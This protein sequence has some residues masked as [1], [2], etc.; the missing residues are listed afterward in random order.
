M[1]KVKILQGIPASGK[2]TWAREFVSKN[3]DWIIVSRDSLRRMRGEYWIPSQEGLITEWEHHLIFSTL[4]I[5]KL[6]VIVDATNLNPTYL[7]ILKKRLKA[8][9]HKYEIKKFDVSLEE[10]IK[11]D[12]KREN[13]VGA[14]VIKKFWDNYYAAPPVPKMVQNENLPIAIICDIDGTIADKGSRSPFDY[15]K[16]DKDKPKEEIIEI[17]KLMKNDNNTIIFFTGRENVGN[18]KEKTKQWILNNLN[19]NEEQ[20][21]LYMR[22]ESDRRK[23][24]IVKKEMFDKYVKE[25]FNVKFV[26]DDRN[27]VVDMWRK[28]LGL[29][30]LQVDYGDF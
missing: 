27:Q 9:N 26:L 15:E 21:L 22:N 16:V 5:F 23:D 10:A 14:D 11:R 12:N 28:E 17:V 4:N 7:D 13:G 25:K 30:C 19:L 6:N 8:E 20:Y 1:G 3:K 2:S 24:S 29:T 18:C